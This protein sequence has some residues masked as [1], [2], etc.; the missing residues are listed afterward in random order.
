MMYQFLINYR[1]FEIFYGRVKVSKFASS[2]SKKRRRKK[3]QSNGI[4]RSKITRRT[5]K[6][7]GRKLRGGGILRLFEK[8]PRSTNITLRFSF[9]FSLVRYLRLFC[10]NF[11]D[12][13]I[14][15]I[16]VLMLNKITFTPALVS[17]KFLYNC[18]RSTN[19]KQALIKS[20]DSWFS[21]H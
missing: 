6:Q 3:N 17:R 13:I 14:F 1:H 8:S 10:Q 11:L 7:G 16:N 18:L 4:A 12:F 2:F 20:N 21:I 5:Q 15:Q 19:D 9:L